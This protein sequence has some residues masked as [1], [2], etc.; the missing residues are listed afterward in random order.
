MIAWRHFD[1]STPT[2]LPL[3]FWPSSDVLSP[4]PQTGSWPRHK[5]NEARTQISI[6]HSMSTRHVTYHVTRESLVMQ[7]GPT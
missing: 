6:P 1:S 7:N 2:F 3:L 5:G 4:R